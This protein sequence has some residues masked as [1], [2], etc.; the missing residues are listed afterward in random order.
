MSFAIHKVRNKGTHRRRS[1]TKQYPDLDCVFLNAGTQNRYELAQPSTV[2][3]EAFHDEINTN[4]NS[5]VDLS[6]KFLP[7]LMNKT[8]HASII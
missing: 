4:F 8:G 7:S 6:I 1:I 2:N 5:F 3:L